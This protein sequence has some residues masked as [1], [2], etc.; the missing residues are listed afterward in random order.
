MIKLR[1]LISEDESTADK[2]MKAAKKLEYELGKTYSVIN[3]N[4]KLIDKNLSSFNA[5]GLKAAFLDG[6]KAGVRGQKYDV[7]AS[8]KKFGNYF[9]R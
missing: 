9:K 4:L 2:D 7:R 8:Q 6:I 5:P 1:N 3:D